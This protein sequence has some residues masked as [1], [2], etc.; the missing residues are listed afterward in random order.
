MK[1][2]S[3]TSNFTQAFISAVKA[4]IPNEVFIPVKIFDAIVIAG[5]QD[6]ST[7]TCYVDSLDSSIES[8][9]V[10]YMLCISDGEIDIPADDSV[11]TVIMSQFTDPYISKNTELKSKGIY[12][13]QSQIYIDKNGI[14]ISNGS[15]SLL[16]VLSD[17]LTAIQNIT[18][19][20]DDGDSGTPNNSIDFVNLSLRLQNVLQ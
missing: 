19:S 17:I 18:V 6:P 4:S 10:R 15:E 2:G 9:Q 5:S 8:F 20:T 11:V 12:I 7:N 3:P 14:N 13:Q 16:S 1:K